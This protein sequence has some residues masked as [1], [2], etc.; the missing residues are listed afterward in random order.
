IVAGVIVCALMLMI[1]TLSA[2]STSS[3]S[4]S[5]A[6]LILLAA[7]YMVA[8]AFALM[9]LS[10]LYPINVGAIALG[11]AVPLVAATVV[12]AV[13]TARM[14]SADPASAAEHWRM[15]MFYYNPNDVQVVVPKR[16]G[17]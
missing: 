7:Q 11:L 16:W 2:Q 12:L 14:P 6:L 15:G 5:P 13:R 10:V 4:A 1:A 9:P 3:A 8:C 17:F